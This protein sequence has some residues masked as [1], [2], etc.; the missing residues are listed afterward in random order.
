M[1]PSS[2]SHILLV[3]T[4]MAVNNDYNHLSISSFG[5]YLTDYNSLS[6]QNISQRRIIQ[7]KLIIQNIKW[8]S[9][10]KLLFF[11]DNPANITD[12]GIGGVNMFSMIGQRRFLSQ[13]NSIKSLDNF[14]ISL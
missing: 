13:N 11:T 2:L 3:S 4:K 14:K 12:E 6:D 1:S 5:L 7:T 10:N 8:I 9:S